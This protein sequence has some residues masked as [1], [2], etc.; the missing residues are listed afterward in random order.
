MTRFYPDTNAVHLLEQTW[1]PEAFDARA[2]ASDHILALGF[3]VIYEL[4]RGFRKPEHRCAVSAAC[5]FLSEIRRVE[6]QPDI[7]AIV[8]AD[9][10]RAVTGLELVTVLGPED[11]LLT[12]QELMT[13]AEGRTTAAALP[14]IENRE[15]RARL[16][17]PQ[18]ATANMRSIRSALARNALARK[19]CKTF[20]GFRQYMSLTAPPLFRRLA[21]GQRVRVTEPGIRLILADLGKFPVVSTWLNAQWYMMWVSAKDRNVP[22]RDK[23][24]DFR[25]LTESARCDVFVTDDRGFVKRAHNIS[26]FR[27]TIS[28]DDLHA[29]LS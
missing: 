21:L 13:M 23:L 29:R 19:L 24:D 22:A 16:H 9:F 2:R 18:L 3:H 1:T 17:H 7:H 28:W 8:R 14:F 5:R 27:P 25:H 15:A 12:R 11:Q 6:I 10:H 4:T 26:P 20:Q